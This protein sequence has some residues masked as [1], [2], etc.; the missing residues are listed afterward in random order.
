MWK[1]FSALWSYRGFVISSV[2][3]EFVTR[4]SRSSLGGI[5]MILHPLAQVSIF[6]LILSNVLAAR[7]PGIDNPHAYALYL[8][9]GTLAWNL[10]NELVS[11]C[12]TLFIDNASLL[13]KM[14]FPRIALPVTVS[15]S[16]IL[17]NAFLFLSILGIFSML[18]KPPTLQAL[19]I[20]VLTLLVA[21]LGLGVGLILG[22][23]NVFLRDI[24][25]VVPVV[26]QIVF[27]F[28]PIVYPVSTIPEH[29]RHLLRL[30]PLYI[31]VNAYQ[32]VLVYQ[33]GPDLMELVP[34]LLLS[35]SLIL[36]GLFLFRRASPELVD[37]L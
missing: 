25:Q 16:C 13:K 24:G 7:L 35:L 30:N 15:S 14:S 19:W 31:L 17:N 33:K 26:M 32:S 6:A 5:W 34:V 3:N 29:Y 18:G 9:A 2:R 4:F 1:M 21:S 10:F 11:R 27:W 28:T 12:L 37:V 36:L 20:P 23:L 22:T 8:M